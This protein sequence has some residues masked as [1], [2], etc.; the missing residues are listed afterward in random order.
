MFDKH[1]KKKEQLLFQETQ[2]PFFSP[3]EHHTLVCEARKQQKQGLFNTMSYH[4]IIT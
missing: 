2:V 4:H 3:H 1:E